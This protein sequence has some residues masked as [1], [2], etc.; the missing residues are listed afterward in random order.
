[1]KKL[2]LLIC[3]AIGTSQISLGQTSLP[4]ASLPKIMLD[5]NTVVKDS[6]GHQYTYDVWTALLSSG[7]F[8]IK[9]N[10][11]NTTE[12]KAPEYIIF[13]VKNP[14]SQRVYS[15]TRTPQKPKESEQFHAGDV[16]KPFKE[17]ALDGEKIDLKKN[18]GK[19]YVINFW[20]IGCPPCR[21]E[22]PELNAL[23]DKYKDNKDVVFVAIC[24]DDADAI[25][26]YTKIIPFNYHQI[27]NARFIAEKYGVHL[28]PTNVVVNRDGKVAYS[29]VSNQPSNPYWLSKTIDESLTAPPA[30]PPTASK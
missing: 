4:P 8:N 6:L 5:A 20:F 11:T 7:K 21:A 25:N 12:D 19:V 26:T 10:R 28:Y 14:N 15:Q 27:D 9:R 18:A 24:L 13:A 23:A 22:I 2:I 3:L 29:A 17:K 30:A 1:M 16:F